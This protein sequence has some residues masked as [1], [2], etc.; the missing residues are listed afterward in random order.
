MKKMI[1]LVVLA[2]LVVA[3]AA[4]GLHVGQ[5]KGYRQAYADC[6]VTVKTD[7]WYLIH[8]VGQCEECHAPE[9]HSLPGLLVYGS[10]ANVNFSSIGY[11]TTG[12][13]ASP[14]EEAFQY[15]VLRDFIGGTAV[16][17]LHK[18]YKEN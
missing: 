16:S 5:E 1:S 2:L 8:K 9:N 7:G 12:G 4:V 3:A 11:S 10:K 14:E 18:P 13:E 15:G 6:K 17:F